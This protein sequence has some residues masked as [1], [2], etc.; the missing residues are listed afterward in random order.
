MNKIIST[1]FSIALALELTVIDGDSLR[2]DGTEIRLE[3]IDAPEWNQTCVDAQ[4]ATFSCGAA[5][6]DDVTA[7]LAQGVVSCVPD[8]TDFYGRTLAH[9]FAGGVEVNGA[10]VDQGMARAFVKYSGEYLANEAEAQH[11]KRGLWAGSW[12]APWDFR[13]Q[14]RALNN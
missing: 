10:M 7:I 1:A 3:G 4:G 8:G 13:K 2:V 11:A 14:E 12:Q 5:A 6:K 9:C